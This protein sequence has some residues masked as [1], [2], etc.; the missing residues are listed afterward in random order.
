MVGALLENVAW[1]FWKAGY[2]DMFRNM[3]G[4][5]RIN[6]PGP[7]CPGEKYSCVELMK[8]VMTPAYTNLCIWES[9]GDVG[10]FEFGCLCKRILSCMYGW[11]PITEPRWK[12]GD[13]LRECFLSFHLRR[14]H[15]SLSFS[16]PTHYQ[17]GFSLP[18]SRSQYQGLYPLQENIQWAS[19][20]AVAF[21]SLPLWRTPFV[22]VIPPSSAILVPQLSVSR[23]AGPFPRIM[24]TVVSI[25][26][27]GM[28][29][30]LNS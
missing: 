24:L 27:K 6:I 9:G 30:L 13:N 1:P 4:D 12:S 25:V 28:L 29:Y 2:L 17:K 23:W 11:V 21:S 7:S 22:P 8:Q 5:S 14:F 10:G 18:V 16:L 3:W 15:Q 19:M 20:E 26:S